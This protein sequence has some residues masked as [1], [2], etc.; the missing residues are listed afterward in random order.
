MF[1]RSRQFV[2]VEGGYRLWVE[3]VGDPRREP[4]V[5]VMG[6]NASGLGWPD[7]LVEMFAEQHFVVRYDHRDTG[8]ST[9]AFD[10]RPYPLMALAEDLMAVLDALGVDAAHVFGMSLGGTLVQVLLVDR[11]DRW[12]SA[13]LVGTPALDDDG[14]PGPAEHLLQLWSEMGDPRD[15]VAERAWQLNHQRVLHGSVIP[16]DVA[17]YEELERRVAD[18]RGSAVGGSAH[19]RAAQEGLDRDLS[20]VTTPTLVIDAPEDP[21]APPPTASRLVSRIPGARLSVVPGM[22][23]S[24]PRAIHEPLAA[25]VLRH[26]SAASTPRGD[27]DG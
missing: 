27:L 17:E 8:R 21:V 6:A 24:L 18:H 26:T 2:E 5:L 7:E 12:L 23:H 25:E 4:L 1:E 9:H 3:T 16:F 13:T 15:P 10:E 20:L 22:G 14:E 19:A 11:P